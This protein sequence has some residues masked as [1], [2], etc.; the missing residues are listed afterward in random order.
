[1]FFK[2]NQ[3]TRYSAKLL[4]TQDRTASRPSGT[5]TFRMASANSGSVAAD[6]TA[7]APVAQEIQTKKIENRRIQKSHSQRAPR[8]RALILI[9][10]TG[11]SLSFHNKSNFFPK[12]WK[13]RCCAHCSVRWLRIANNCLVETIKFEFK[14]NGARKRFRTSC[15][16]LVQKV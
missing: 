15:S 13:W 10:S 12:N 8:R 9:S 4:T 7:L 16:L 14:K 1:M 2:K 3:I 5:V 11:G 6:C